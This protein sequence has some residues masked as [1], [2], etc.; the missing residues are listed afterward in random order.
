MSADRRSDKIVVSRD[1]RC[2]LSDEKSG[3]SKL[4]NR[5][6]LPSPPIENLTRPVEVEP[7]EGVDCRSLGADWFTLISGTKVKK[8]K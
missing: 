3:L 6:Y 1:L 7:T 4:F 5:T 8:I 2:T